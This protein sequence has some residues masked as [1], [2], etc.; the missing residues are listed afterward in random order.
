MTWFSLCHWS[1]S[2]QSSNRREVS[3]TEAIIERLEQRVDGVDD[4]V[5][6]RDV[7]RHHL[8]VVHFDAT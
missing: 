3:F 7:V 8:R 4:S 5:G 6:G 2:R 1:V